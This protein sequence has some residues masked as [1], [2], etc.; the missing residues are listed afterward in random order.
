VLTVLSAH[1][2]AFLSECQH[3]SIGTKRDAINI[4]KLPELV[5]RPQ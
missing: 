1:Q 3:R 4:A 2:L 5:K